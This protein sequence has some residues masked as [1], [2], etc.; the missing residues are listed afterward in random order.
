M[1]EVPDSERNEQTPDDTDDAVETPPGFNVY[2]DA[3]DQ[4][5]WRFVHQ[6]GNII[7]DSGQGYGR[8]ADAVNGIK[9]L[10]ENIHVA[11]IIDLSKPQGTES[12][13]KRARRKFADLA[14]RVRGEFPTGGDADGDGDE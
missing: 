8:K 11:P 9:S 4:W 5:R 1:S 3:A 6:N 13:L 10:E 2:R 14:D 12:R 7:A